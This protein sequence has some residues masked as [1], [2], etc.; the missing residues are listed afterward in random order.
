[1]KDLPEGGAEIAPLK[2][3]PVHIE[4]SDIIVEVLIDRL[5]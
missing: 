4:G 2:T 1:V 3:Y 5:P